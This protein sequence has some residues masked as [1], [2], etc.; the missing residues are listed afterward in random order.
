[1]Q[2]RPRDFHRLKKLF[3]ETAT[4]FRVSYII[5]SGPLNISRLCLAFFR[6]L[7]SKALR[8]DTFYLGGLGL[9]EKAVYFLKK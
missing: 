6:Y 3:L 7:K 2:I 9:V 5:L 4:L 8:W 1:M